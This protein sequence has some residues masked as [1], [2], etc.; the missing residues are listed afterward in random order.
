MWHEK[1]TR[2]GL[3]SGQRVREGGLLLPEFIC[4]SPAPVSSPTGVSH[5]ELVTALAPL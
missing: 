1:A 3:S 5:E 2:S 4:Q